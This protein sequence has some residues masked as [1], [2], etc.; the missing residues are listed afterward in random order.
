MNG[1]MFSLKEVAVLTI[2]F[3]ASNS[4]ILIL[5]ELHEF[6]SY[7]SIFSLPRQSL[8]RRFQ[9]VVVTGGEQSSALAK[10]SLL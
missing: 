8:T 6:I 7:F 10:H 4:T 2:S 3:E 1:T 9:V 5:H